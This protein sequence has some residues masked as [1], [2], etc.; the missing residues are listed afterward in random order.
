MLAK[1]LKVRFRNEEKDICDFFFFF[2][3]WLGETIYNSVRFIRDILK[4]CSTTYYIGQ[5][6]KY[7]WKYNIFVVTKQRVLRDEN[8][9]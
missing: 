3:K 1:L 6:Y 7:Y 4:K 5:K 2:I 8:A 9:G